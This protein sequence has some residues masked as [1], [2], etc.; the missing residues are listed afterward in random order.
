[1]EDNFFNI[2]NEDLV[3]MF[4]KKEII[5]QNKIISL[6]DLANLLYIDL[7]NGACK[8]DDT[9]ILFAKMIEMKKKINNVDEEYK[10]LNRKTF[11]QNDVQ[12]KSQKTFINILKNNISDKILIILTIAAIFSIGIGIGKMFLS[13]EKLGVIEGICILVAVVIIVSVGTINEY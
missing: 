9:K 12:L 4:N 8:I 13:D 1:M 2:T 3:N 6:E 7:E 11:G 10:I 5:Y